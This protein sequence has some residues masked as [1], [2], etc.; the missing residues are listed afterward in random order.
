MGWRT[1]FRTLRHHRWLSLQ[2]TNLLV[3]A[4]TLKRKGPY[5]HF[6]FEGIREAVVLWLVVLT[7]YMIPAI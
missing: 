4:N 1:S 7:A 6:K 5:F 3:A 2:Q